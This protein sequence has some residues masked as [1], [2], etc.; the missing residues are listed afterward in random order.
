MP[1]QWKMLMLIA[2]LI[3]KVIACRISAIGAMIK[4]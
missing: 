3:D 1:D 2:T 4:T